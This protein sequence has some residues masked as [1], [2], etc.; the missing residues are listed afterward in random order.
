M[1]E[2]LDELDGSHQGERV[3]RSDQLAQPRRGLDDLVAEHAFDEGFRQL[4]A[5][6]I[7]SRDRFEQRPCRVH[8][9][10]KVH[11]HVVTV[12]VADVVTV[13]FGAAR[14]GFHGRGAVVFGRLPLGATPCRKAL[15][16]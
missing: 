12:M 2:L 4:R 1:A 5:A 7:S 13:P 9:T 10:I 14:A 15:R 8:V 6:L 11:G 3:T 16:F